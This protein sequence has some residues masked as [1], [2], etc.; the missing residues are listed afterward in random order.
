MSEL[1]DKFDVWTH[2]RPKYRSTTPDPKRGEPRPDKGRKG[3]IVT[4][5][6]PEHPET[7]GMREMVDLRVMEAMVL[8]RPAPRDL[9]PGGEGFMIALMVPPEMEEM[10]AASG[11]WHPE[12]GRTWKDQLHCTVAYIDDSDYFPV[13]VKAAKAV[14]DNVAPME[15]VTTRIGFFQQGEKALVWYVGVAAPELQAVVAKLR[16]ELDRLK[17]PHD[18]KYPVYT[19]HITLGVVE[20]PKQADMVAVVNRS[21]S[22]GPTRFMPTPAVVNDDDRVVLRW[23]TESPSPELSQAIAG[24]M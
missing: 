10:V 22:S 20:N 3:P 14:F 4:F 12:E 23:S 8:S 6:Q 24:S 9:R 15:L 19:P 5:T 16:W 17:V 7:R 13:A 2:P 11:G 1:D 18:K 21:S